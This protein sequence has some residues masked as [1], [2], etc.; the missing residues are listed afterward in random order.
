MAKRKNWYSKELAEKERRRQ[1]REKIDAENAKSSL[2]A[3]L[4]LLREK[5]G[6]TQSEVAEKLD[7]QRNA[8]SHYE[9]GR[10]KPSV[11]QLYYL[12]KIFNID[13]EKLVNVYVYRNDENMDL[14]KLLNEEE[15]IDLNTIEDFKKV[16]DSLTNDNKAYREFLEYM[17]V[18]GTSKKD[19]IDIDVEEMV[20]YYKHCSTVERM[21]I[22]S[23]LQKIYISSRYMD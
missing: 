20:F 14:I 1:E 16:F 22:K 6:L 23:L 10:N 11:E 18:K 12:S 2:A 3:Y 7:M 4:R 19:G 13:I 8:Y 9:T 21:M 15:K 17:Q 5:K